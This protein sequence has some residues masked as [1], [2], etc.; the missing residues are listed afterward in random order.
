MSKVTK[1]QLLML[2]S[3]SVTVVGVDEHVW[4]GVRWSV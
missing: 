3:F 4:E 1:F 2:V